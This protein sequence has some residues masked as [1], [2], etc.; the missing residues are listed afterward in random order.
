VQWRFVRSTH[1]LLPEEG[2]VDVDRLLEL[3]QYILHLGISG[4]PQKVEDVVPEPLVLA[5]REIL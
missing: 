4:L 5:M 1:D 2:V 3:F